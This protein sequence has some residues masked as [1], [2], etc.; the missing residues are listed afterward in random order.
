M[1]EVWHW[2]TRGGTAKLR[3]V[4]ATTDAELP[5]PEEVLGEV[6]H[7]LAH[8]DDDGAQIYPQEM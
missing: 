2:Q 1:N 8:L 7:A 3:T 4:R 5:D 6:A